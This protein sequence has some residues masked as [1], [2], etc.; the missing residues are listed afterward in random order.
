MLPA[1][2][3]H[4]ILENFSLPATKLTSYLP[5]SMISRVNFSLIKL[6]GFL[7][8][9]HP[10]IPKCWCFMI[11]TA[12]TYMESSWPPYMPSLSL[13][14]TSR[15]LKYSSKPDYN[16][17]Y[18]NSIMNYPYSY[19]VLW[20]HWRLISNWNHPIFPIAILSNAPFTPSRKC[21]SLDSVAQMIFSHPTSGIN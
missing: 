20:K 3:S 16:P 10:D 19:K 1:Q 5:P 18:K 4:T 17:S 8:P 7:L 2:D 12:N 6:A 11:M 9:Q 14:P 15:P 21:L 13:P